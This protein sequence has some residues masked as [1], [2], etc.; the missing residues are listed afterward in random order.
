M[1]FGE[2]VI[3]RPVKKSDIQNFVKWMNDQEVNQYT[4]HDLPVTEI[5][6]EN[7]VNNAS[8][9]TDSAILVIETITNSKPIGNCGIH[10]IHL[11]YR[12]ATF[13]IIIGDKDYWSKGY[14]S[15]A[16]K[17][18][19]D[20]A[21][22]RLNLNRISSSV[23]DLNPRS[24]ALHKKLGFKEEGRRRQAYYKNG[25]YCDEIILGILRREW[26]EMKK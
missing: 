19:V 13:G 21:F 25:N 14:G 11:I 15:E 24:L 1:L 8:T 6:E 4:C 7:W 17:L 18:L 23:L 3:L 12:K 20:Y 22:Y 9:K 26:E 10:G 16:G 2:K 5:S